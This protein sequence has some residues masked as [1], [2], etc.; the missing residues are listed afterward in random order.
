MAPLLYS[1]III[2]WKLHLVTTNL[3]FCIQN[4][5]GS[6]WYSRHCLEQK[7]SHF[8]I[9]YASQCQI[10]HQKSKTNVIKSKYIVRKR[11]Y[12]RP[13]YNNTTVLWI[14]KILYRVYIDIQSYDKSNHTF[15]PHKMTA[16][17]LRRWIYHLVWIHTCTLCMARILFQTTF[18]TIS[19]P[20]LVIT[21]KY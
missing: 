16:G 18:E 21:Y 1:R 13:K 15:G 14:L 8:V 20:R 7:I 19:L 17:S 9:K 6:H 10:L 2:I 12:C 5:L 4:I 11:D 3:T